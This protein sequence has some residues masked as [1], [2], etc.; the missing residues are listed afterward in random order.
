MILT[1]DEKDN[2]KQL[3]QTYESKNITLALDIL[4]AYE[5]PTHEISKLFHIH[6]FSSHDEIGNFVVKSLYNP[7]VP[8]SEI[9]II[10]KDGRLLKLKSIR[11]PKYVSS[12]MEYVSFFYGIGG[13]YFKNKVRR[14]QREYIRIAIELY[15]KHN[16]IKYQ[17]FNNKKQL[18]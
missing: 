16:G 6:D 3:I 11:L 10:N 9:G 18:L 13:V 8:V 5:Y 17:S 15:Y 4:A 12:K 2:V 14:W 1:D 7:S